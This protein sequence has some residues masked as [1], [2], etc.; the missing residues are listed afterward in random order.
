MLAGNRQ[1]LRLMKGFG[2]HIDRDEMSH[3]VREVV[4]RL[5]A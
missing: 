1:A 4:T 3:G 2:T 5:A